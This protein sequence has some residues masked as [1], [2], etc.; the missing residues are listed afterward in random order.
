MK[1]SALLMTGLTLLGFTTRLSDKINLI[2]GMG[3][4]RTMSEWRAK[5][6]GQ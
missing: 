5:L 2:A 1:T 4:L 6:D 3:L